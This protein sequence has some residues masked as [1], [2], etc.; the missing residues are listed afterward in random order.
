MSNPC[1][2]FGLRANDPRSAKRRKELIEEL[3]RRSRR[4]LHV[5]DS[6]APQTPAPQKDEIDQIARALCRKTASEPRREAVVRAVL[7]P[8][9]WLHDQLCH[10]RPPFWAA[11]FTAAAFATAGQLI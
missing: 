10:A 11:L 8:P 1:A 4:P 6:A 3:Q 9:T 2:Q 5:R 7:R